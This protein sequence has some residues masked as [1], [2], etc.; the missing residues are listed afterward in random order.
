MQV[1][2]DVIQIVHKDTYKEIYHNISDA[3][4]LGFVAYDKMAGIQVRLYQPAKWSQLS[5]PSVDNIKL[6]HNHSHRFHLTRSRL[7]AGVVK[8]PS[9]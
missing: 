6:K 8:I 5:N 4:Q 2:M 1:C 9:V 7:K 3:D